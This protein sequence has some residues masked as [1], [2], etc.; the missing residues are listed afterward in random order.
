[1][2]WRINRLAQFSVNSVVWKLRFHFYVF[3]NRLIHFLQISSH[4]S[5]LLF[6]PR[7]GKSSKLT[8]YSNKRFSSL[9]MKNDERKRT[10]SGILHYMLYSLQHHLPFKMAAEQSRTTTLTCKVCLVVNLPEIALTLKKCLIQG[11]NHCF[12]YLNWAP[13]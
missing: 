1:M 4:L 6:F 13:F 10:L 5:E 3:L 12:L 11:K 9:S 8:M 7:P 2:D